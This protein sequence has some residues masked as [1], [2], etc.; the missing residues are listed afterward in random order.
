MT[1]RLAAFLFALLM[2]CLGWSGD[3][4]TY[5]IEDYRV[6]LTPHSDGKV[7]VEY[8]QKWLVTGGHIPWI[9]VGVPNSQFAIRE[10]KGAARNLS[11]ASGGGWAGVRVDLD[12]DYQPGESFAIGFSIEQ[13]GLFYAAGDNVT[14]GFTPGWYDRAAIGQLTVT[15]NIAAQASEVKASPAPTKEEGQEI[16]WVRQDLAPGQQARFSASFPKARMPGVVASHRASPRRISP[17]LIL[18]LVIVG[19]V[20]MVWILSRM[21]RGGIGRGGYSR[22]GTIFYG[23]AR[24]S[25]G[26]WRSSSGGGGFGG[27]SSSCACACVSC[28]CACACA[29]GG[30]AGCARKTM[31]VCDLCRN[32]QGTEA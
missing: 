25:G 6:R 28:A 11:N 16:T 8:Q 19:V 1:A 21:G 24:G 22:G 17:G 10:G 9:T 30:G 31:H 27:S 29:G 32:R 12:K 3:T 13:S 18:L 26:G 2:P 23:G 4:G 15:M 20:L 5:R 14:L 7:T